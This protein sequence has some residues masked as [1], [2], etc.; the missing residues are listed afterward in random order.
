MAD[1]D[2]KE[3]T[4][5][6]DFSNARVKEIELSLDEFVFEMNDEFKDEGL[7]TRGPY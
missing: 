5:M 2:A 4:E 1:S 3:L 6:P 7:I